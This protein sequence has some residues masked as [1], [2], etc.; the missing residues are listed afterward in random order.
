MYSSVASHTSWG[1]SATKAE[2][3][4]A[5]WGH[6]IWVSE[7]SSFTLPYHRLVI[8]DTSAEQE[9]TQ[10][11]ELYRNYVGCIEFHSGRLADEM[12]GNHQSKSLGFPKQNALN[13]L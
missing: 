10:V 6:D 5:N 2:S 9:R 1:C 4:L 3:L 11:G 12:Y 13:S 8:T 7:G